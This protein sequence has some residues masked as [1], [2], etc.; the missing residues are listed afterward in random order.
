VTPK[1]FCLALLGL[2]AL[3]LAGAAGLVYA[4]D[5]FNLLG[6]N[7][8]GVHAATERQAK[9]MLLRRGGYGAVLIGSSKTAYI[10]PDRLCLPGVF[11]ASFAA[12]VPEEMLEF[13]RLH[14]RPGQAALVG[15]DLFMFNEREAPLLPGEAGGLPEAGP[16]RLLGYLLGWTPLE[17]AAQALVRHWRGR[18]PFMRANGSRTAG[19][20]LARH[21]RMP[22]ADH[23]AA[24]EHLM[25]N[26]YRDFAFSEARLAVLREMRAVLEAKGG[27]YRVFVSPLAAPVVARLR[28]DPAARAQQ[29]RFRR[30]LRAVFPDLVD[31]SESR[32]SAP[33]NFFRFDPLHYLPEA[34]ARFMNE[35]VLRDWCGGA[36]EDGPT[37]GAALP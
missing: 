3:L 1:R 20:Q 32:Y 2:Y 7:W 35:A 8:T 29:E 21:A 17:R 34:G 15:L 31:L 6:R 13:L 12:A 33:E 10:D 27:P 23:D 28:A 5:P 19:E 30:E 37:I 22:E 4:V 18:E 24:V 36:G 25:A 11:N 14:L 26:H 16:R 9:P